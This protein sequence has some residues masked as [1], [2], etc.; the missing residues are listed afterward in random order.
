MIIKEPFLLA[1][2][3]TVIASASAR[4]RRNP[5]VARYSAEGPFTE[6]A[7]AARVASGNRSRFRTTII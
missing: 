7:A 2:L 6:P 4:F 3:G 5:V 1:G